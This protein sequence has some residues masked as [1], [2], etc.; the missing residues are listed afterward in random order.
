LFPA[1]SKYVIIGAGIHG[2]STA[3]HLAM[4]LQARKLGDGS[5]VVVIDKGKLGSGASGIACGVI[6]NNYYQPAMRELMAHSVEVWE[7]DQEAFAYN[8]VGYLQISHEGMH[9]DVRGIFEEQKSIGYDSEFI[10][11][12]KSSDIFMKKMFHDWQA[13]NIT[14]VLHEKKGGFAHNQL[15]LEGLANKAISLGV[16]IFFD[17]EVI[18]FNRHNGNTNSIRIIETNKGTVECD[19]V[20]LGV[21]PWIRDFWDMLELPKKI[22]LNTTEDIEHKDFDMWTFWQLQEGVLKVNP[23]FFGL[24][25]GGIPPVIHIDSNAP[26]LSAVDGEIITEDN[27]GIYYKPDIHFDGI[28]GGAMPYEI[29]TPTADVAIDP[30]GP[31]SPEFISSPDFALMWCSALAH[32]HKRFDGKIAE[33]DNTPSGGIGCFSPD[34]FPVIDVFFENC[35]VIADSNHGYK[36]IGIGKLIA[37]EIVSERSELLKPFQYDR[38]AKGELHP[39]SNSP[40]PWS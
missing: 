39:S 34:C 7:S 12:A 32:C 26:L 6:R 10:E 13:K 14:S 21:G 2:L 22:T 4:E 27:W 20:V 40:F 33:Y 18:G 9:E 37:K 23:K 1:Q 28:Q 31:A 25:N 17:T 36:M 35:H 11:G 16:R 8:P 30:Y 29:A 15:S 5:D 19:Y 3:Y 38:F 24:N